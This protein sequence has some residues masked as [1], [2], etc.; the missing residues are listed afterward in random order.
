[1]EKEALIGA[2]NSKQRSETE[3]GRERRHN[4]IYR[5]RRGSEDSGSADRTDGRS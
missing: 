5:N 1:M 2:M 3:R 4:R